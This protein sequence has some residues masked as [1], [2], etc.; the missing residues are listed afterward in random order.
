VN[1]LS[2]INPALAK[3]NPRPHPTL[4]R[5]ACECVRLFACLLEHASIELAV[6]TGSNTEIR[7]DSP[8]HEK[9]APR[10]VLCCA[11][12]WAHVMHITLMSFALVWRYLLYS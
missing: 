3:A 9:E 12:L 11:V 1:F 10:G 5:C 7:F 4:K 8:I 6:Q 2:I